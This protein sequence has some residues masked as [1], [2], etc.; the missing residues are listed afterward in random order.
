MARNFSIN[1]ITLPDLKALP[2]AGLQ[3]WM[4]S[5]K[6][7]IAGGVY[8]PTLTN[9][10]NLAASTAYECQYQQVENI[11]WVSGRVDVDPTSTGATELGISLP[12]E[13]DITS[14]QQLAG[15]GSSPAVAGMC[16]AALG[17]TTN[18]RASLQW[19]AADT[20]N[21][22]VYFTFMYRIQ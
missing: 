1:G 18:D 19:V 17:D 4:R 12:I 22:A 6:R 5:V 20:S 10:T 21:R 16:I 13:T 7:A 11:V 15:T 9:G 2:F 3:E 8:T 14:T